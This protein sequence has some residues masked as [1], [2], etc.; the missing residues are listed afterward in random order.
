MKQEIEKSFESIAELLAAFKG[1]GCDEILVKPLATNQDNEKNQIYLGKNM[2]MASYLPGTVSLRAPSSSVAKHLSN[3]GKPIVSLQLDFYWLWPGGISSAAPNASIIEYSQYPEVRLS[4]FSSSSA[5][6]PHALRRD[7]QEL[8][9]RR[10]LVLGISEAKVFGSVVTEVGEPETV[11]GFDYLPSWPLQPLLKVLD[12]GSNGIDEARLIDEVQKICGRVHKPQV[13]KTKADTPEEIAPVPQAGGWTLEALLG[14]PR[15]S[16]SE[17]DKY[18]FE[19]KAVGGSRTSLITTEPDLGFRAEAGVTAFLRKYGKAAKADPGKMVFNGLQRCGQPNA[20]TGTFL[21]IEN[22]DFT[23]NSPT[24]Q[25]QPNV[26]LIENRSEVVVAGWSFEKLASSW[27]KKHAGALYVETKK[28]KL[29]SEK[30]EGYQFGSIG[31]LGKGTNPLLLLTHI[32]KGQV[33]LDPG[34]SKRADSPAK[35][36]TQWR[37]NGDIAGQL[38]DGLRPLYQEFTSLEL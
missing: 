5:R 21:T 4:G 24:G 3:P 22:W 33:F 18:G 19:I 20:T 27:T 16:R 32:A 12:P 9:G 26:L 38:A 36:R 7:F 2:T 14:I 6:S 35:S 10:Y 30:V 37:V 1:V 17:P 28:V 13:L 23:T 8:Y 25:G 31:L 34:D 11:R 29:P 15:N